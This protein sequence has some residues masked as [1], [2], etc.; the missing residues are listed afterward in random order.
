MSYCSEETNV[1]MQNYRVVLNF[2]TTNADIFSPPVDDCC[3]ILA[4]S[5]SILDAT[6]DG[7]QLTYQN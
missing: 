6:I 2:N 5:R 3:E 7:Q 4:R 1:I